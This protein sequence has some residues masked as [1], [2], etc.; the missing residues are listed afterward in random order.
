MV[1]EVPLRA[2]FLSSTYNIPH[3]PT[4]IKFSHSP[5]TTHDVTDGVVWLDKM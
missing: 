1:D 2:D 4:F 3:K 5:V